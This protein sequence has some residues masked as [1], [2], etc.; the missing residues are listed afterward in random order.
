MCS[1]KDQS[2]TN[3]HPNAALM[4]GFLKEKEHLSIY[5]QAVRYPS[6][7][8]LNRLNSAFQRFYT[9]IQLTNYLTTTLSFYASNYSKH[10]ARKRDREL[11]ILDQPANEEHD[12]SKKDMLIARDDQQ[13]YGWEQAIQD[14]AL[15]SAIQELPDKQKQHLE[16]C[17]VHQLTH[18]EIADKLDISQQAVSKSIQSALNKIR[19]ALSKGALP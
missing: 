7:A 14:P 11:I 5:Q 9:E 12:S 4:N 10:A 17:F 19:T 2:P 15:F 18:T 6:A 13:V 1:K 8:N 3:I 16:L